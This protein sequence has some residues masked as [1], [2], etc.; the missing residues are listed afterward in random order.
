M[1]AKANTNITC[2]VRDAV[3]RIPIQVLVTILVVIVIY[4]GLRHLYKNYQLQKQSLIQFWFYILSIISLAFS[5]WSV[6]YI[7]FDW[8]AP[9]WQL[10][11]S[12]N[13]LFASSYL[14]CQSIMFLQMKLNLDITTQCERNPTVIASE[15]K[16]ECQSKINKLL[17]I[18]LAGLM[19]LEVA[20]ILI[21]FLK[22]NYQTE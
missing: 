3:W 17:V 22:P 18:G 16:F 15:K 14:Y 1:G 2:G 10:C 11:L 20:N 4:F 13:Q 12:T 5:L 6:W 21:I 19:T 7:C 8:T 9:V